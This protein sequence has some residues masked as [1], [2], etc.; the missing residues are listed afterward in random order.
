MSNAFAQEGA[1]F[2]FRLDPGRIAAGIVTGIGFLGAGTIL[3]HEN[4]VRGLTTAA[5]IWLS[6]S[7]GI[8]IGL[9]YIE[10]AMGATALALFCLIFLG[11]LERLFRK[12]Q[13]NTLTVIA[14][15]SEELLAS[16][17]RLLES[18]HL[19]VRQVGVERDV[20]SQLLTL[21]INVKHRYRESPGHDVTAAVAR[22][23]GIQ[24]VIW[25]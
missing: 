18:L 16:V 11:R 19:I 23:E 5:C 13:Y 25:R 12:D 14:H 7:L 9:G 1:M 22:L 10:L 24:R 17:R 20:S 6:A 2:A 3:R 8:A 15:A 4:L 21:W